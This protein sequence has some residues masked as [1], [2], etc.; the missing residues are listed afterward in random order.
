LREL[1]EGQLANAVIGALSGN[2]E[3]RK[4]LRRLAKQG[5]V[6]AVEPLIALLENFYVCKA[7]CEALNSIYKT[8]KP[9]IRE[10]L[11]RTHLTRFE[12][13]VD[14]YYVDYVACRICGKSD[15]AMFG[16]K[17]IIATLDAGMEE[18][19]ICANGTVRGNWLK[20]VDLFDFDRVEIIQASDYDVERFCIQVGK[21]MDNLRRKRYRK[22]P[23]IVDPR[24]GLSESAMNMLRSRFGKVSE[25]V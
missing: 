6:R 10:M 23:C 7:A 19:F 5:D 2:A 3:A 25:A 15:Q 21:D 14:R 22:M 13:K 11:C 18:D 12:T 9:R 4:E 16:V 24:C 1:G 8:V 17:K 20:R